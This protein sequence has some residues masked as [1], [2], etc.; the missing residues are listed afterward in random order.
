MTER[1][2]YLDAQTSDLTRALET[3]EDAIRKLDARTRALFRKTFDDINAN[4][5]DI[6]PRLF[7]SGG[8]WLGMTGDDFLVAGVAVMVRL[9][10]KRQVSINLLSGG[11]K[12]MTA[13]AVVFSIFALNPA[14]FCLLDEVDAPLDE[15]NIERFCELLKHMS[16]RVQF[17]LIT[18]NKTSMEYMDNLIGV[19]MQEPGVSRL[20]SV[21]VE[22]AAKLAIA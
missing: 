4:L 18:H 6:V 2:Q 12:A 21:D 17:I 5:Q 8:A 1:K 3:L 20:V 19:T 14:P 7:G 13:I 15:H 22:S 10:G 11:E 16:E 9:P